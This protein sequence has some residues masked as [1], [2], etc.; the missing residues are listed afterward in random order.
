MRILVAGPNG[1][2]G[3]VMVELLSRE[4]EVYALMRE[5]CQNPWQR[6]VHIL[7]GD[8]SSFDQLELPS[9]ID[10]VY[11]LAQSKRFREFP[12]GAADMFEVN[13]NVPL[14]LVQWARMSGVRSFVYASTGGVYGGGSLPISESAPI[15]VS[16]SRGF[17]ANSKLSA[18]LLLRSFAEFFERF[19]VVRPF[20]IYGPSQ[21]RLMLIPRLLRTVEEG[22][23]ISLAGEEGIRINPVYVEDAAIACANILR[24]DHGSYIFNIGGN[25]TVSIRRLGIMMGTILGKVPLFSVNGTNADDLVGDI[26]LMRQLLH[27]PLIDLATGFSLMAGAD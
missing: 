27:T 17:Y 9:R 12:D 22:G 3:R 14:K 25:E 13:V 2:L 18:E 6:T 21:D 10:A 16:P 24:L 19:V 8:L 26:S 23:T 20:F 1:L 11:Y 15:A 5:K 4:H 7:T